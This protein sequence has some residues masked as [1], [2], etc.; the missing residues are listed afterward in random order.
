MITNYKQTTHT[1]KNWEK[2]QQVV[3]S[4]VSLLEKGAGKITLIILMEQRK[5]RSTDYV[6][7]LRRIYQQPILMKHTSFSLKLEVLRNIKNFADMQ[8]RLFF[9]GNEEDFEGFDSIPNGC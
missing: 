7:R 8:I 5:N 6:T 4:K 9:F 1:L 3:D 2:R